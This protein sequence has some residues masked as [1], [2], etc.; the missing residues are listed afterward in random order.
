MQ[1]DDI[2][3]EQLPATMSALS[4][5]TPSIH[6]PV[7]VN[8]ELP[9]AAADADDS[10]IMG[11]LGLAYLL[12]QDVCMVVSIAR[13]VVIGY[14]QRNDEA[15]LEEI[16]HDMDHVS[17]VVAYYIPHMGCMLLQDPDESVTNTIQNMKK[18]LYDNTVV[19]R[20]EQMAGA[21]YADVVNAWATNREVKPY[22]IYVERERV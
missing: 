10:V 15:E 8:C 1:L 9:Y 17:D 11:K 20:L 18:Q 3:Y 5:F 16:L 13:E 19:T 12:Q 6:E 7:T 2:E 14:S 4:L 21:A 22:V